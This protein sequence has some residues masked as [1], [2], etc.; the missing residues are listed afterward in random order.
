ME[1]PTRKLAKLEKL[2]KVFPTF[3]REM[4]AAIVD[5]E[6]EIWKETSKENMGKIQEFPKTSKFEKHKEKFDIMKTTEAEDEDDFEKLIEEF[7]L[8]ESY[9]IL[10]N[11][12]IA[13][14]QIYKNDNKQKQ[15]VK[16]IL[17][18]EFFYRRSKLRRFVAWIE[19]IIS[20][21]QTELLEN[22]VVYSEEN[23]KLIEKWQQ[24][25]P[26][27][28]KMYIEK[29]RKIRQKEIEKAQSLKK[30]K[31]NPEETGK[32]KSTDTSPL[33]VSGEEPKPEGLYARLFRLD[34]EDARKREEKWEKEE[35]EYNLR[36]KMKKEEKLNKQKQKDIIN[37]RAAQTPPKN[38]AAEAPSKKS[39]YQIAIEE[40]QKIFKEKE[41][42]NK[43]QLE[44]HRRT[45]ELHNPLRIKSKESAV[46]EYFEHLS[47]SAMEERNEQQEPKERRNTLS[48]EDSSLEDEY[49][50]YLASSD[51][52]V[53]SEDHIFRDGGMYMGQTITP[54]ITREEMRSLNDQRKE[55]IEIKNQ[56]QEKNVEEEIP[57]TLPYVIVLN[58]P[59][60]TQDDVNS[61]VSEDINDKI[62]ITKK[63]KKNKKKEEVFKEKLEFSQVFA[64]TDSTTALAW[65]QS[66]PHKWT[67][68]VSNRVTKIQDN[69][70]PIHW[71]HVS[72]EDN[73]ADPASRGL[74]PS[75][76]LT[77][78]LWWAGPSW[79]REPEDGWPPAILQSSHFFDTKEETQKNV[80]IAMVQTEPLQ[81]LL[82]KF[83][84][85]TKIKR[86]LSYVSR[87]IHNIRF[88]N[89]HKNGAL[90]IADFEL[91]ELYLLRFAQIDSFSHELALI[92]KEKPLPKCLAKLTP[93]VDEKVIESWGA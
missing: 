69:V 92:R 35:L 60:D 14:K 47:E 63:G 77:N 38:A 76:L 36:E 75:E 42:E 6:H 61:P 45:K 19:D 24:L 65:I 86:I 12:E 48:P 20:G 30:R 78:S 73:P 2:G 52:E 91:A 68:F 18:K 23:S 93:F 8:D 57:H 41:A 39:P 26:D 31:A 25:D 9:I 56:Q 88:L 71:H 28:H 66:S 22:P 51:D 17:N 32:N 3:N 79:L 54:L 13:R 49:F 29:V 80:C 10:K 90:T 4:I 87:F 46:E 11:Y 85:L 5:H 74:L 89:N 1:N 44:I 43:R 70:V 16:N 81:K 58:E 37:E 7:Y 15:I 59:M 21:K 34:Q 83:S 40:D 82:E 72:S 62:P 55:N 67:C 64:Y 33:Q 84:S 27:S 50:N 53:T